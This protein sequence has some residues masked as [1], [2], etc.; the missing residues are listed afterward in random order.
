MDTVKVRTGSPTKRTHCVIHVEHAIYSMKQHS[1][2]QGSVPEVFDP[3]G[4]EIRKKRA[5]ETGSDKT[6]CDGAK[7]CVNQ[8][9]VVG[10]VY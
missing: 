4:D 7:I 5:F 1:G 2:S 9:S 10:F 8:L 6:A 3:S